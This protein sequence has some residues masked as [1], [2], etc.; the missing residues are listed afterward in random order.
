[1][2]EHDLSA[3]EWRKSSYSSGEGGNCLEVAEID[4]PVVPVRDSKDPDGPAVVFSADAWA[5]FLA[6]LTP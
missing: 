6:T 4:A 3:A 2:R 5:R 1:M